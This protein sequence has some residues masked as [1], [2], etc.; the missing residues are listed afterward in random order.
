MHVKVDE[1]TQ[2]YIRQARQVKSEIITETEL[3]PLPEPVQRYLRYAQVIGKARVRCVKVRQK[4]LM[5]TTP[6]QPWMPV[7]AVQYSTL[8]GPL[9]RTWYARI[10]MGPFNLLKG[11][12]RYDNGTGSMLIR[13]LSMIP[14]V[15]AYGPEVDMSALIIFINDMVMWPTAF[16]SDYIHWEPIDATSARAR[17]DL[18]GRHFS[19]VLRFNETGEMVDFITED[20]YRSVGKTSQQD[21]WS[22]PLRSYRE[23]NGLRIPSEGDAVWHLPEGEFPY[24]QVSIGEVCYD[25]FDY[26]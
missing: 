1:K 7:E 16:L 18:F 26:D 5:R 20:R 6:T 3:A 21:R 10:K 25:T 8:V 15:D 22:T 17:V 4:G 11:Y 13:L 2:D 23:V 12:D 14:V 19:A 9:S 24:I